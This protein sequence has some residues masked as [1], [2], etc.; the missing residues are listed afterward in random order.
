MFQN[1]PR[2]E[3]AQSTFI[4]QKLVLKPMHL[5]EELIGPKNELYSLNLV[6]FWLN[7]FE[8]ED[9]MSICQYYFQN[10]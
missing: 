6:L 8:N 3:L 4:L 7:I 1:A 10:S 9:L 2:L 5:Y